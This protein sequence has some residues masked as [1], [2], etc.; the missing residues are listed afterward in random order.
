VDAVDCSVGEFEAVAAS[1]TAGFREPVAAQPE[2]AVA[3]MAASSGDS[4]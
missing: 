2:S 3:S 4:E 1:A